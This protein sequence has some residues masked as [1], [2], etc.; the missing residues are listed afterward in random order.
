MCKSNICNCFELDNYD[1]MI[2]ETN[3]M[4]ISITLSALTKLILGIKQSK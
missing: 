4:D 2:F 3:F 1:K